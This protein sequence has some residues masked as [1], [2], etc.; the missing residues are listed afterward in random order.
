MLHLVL[1]WHFHQPD[2]RTDSG[3]ACLPWTYL[4]ALKDY[5]DMAA[6]LEAVPAVRA[7]VNFVPT[8]ADQLDDYA[9]QIQLGPVRDPLLAR[10]IEPDLDRIDP[11]AKRELLAACFRLNRPTMLDP[12][13]A[14]ARLYA[15]Y[16]SALEDAGEGVGYL[17]GQYLADLL[18]WYHLAWMGESI[19]RSSALVARL[20]GQGHGFSLADREA[21][22]ALI[23]EIIG[24]LIP[25]YRALAQRGQIELSSTPYSH[26]MAPLMLDFAAAREARPG[27]TLPEHRAYPDGAARIRAHVAAA[28]TS[29]ASHFGRAPAGFWPAEGGLSEAVLPLLAVEGIDWLASGEGVLRQSL[30]ATGNALGDKAAWGYRPF[31]FGDSRLACFFRDDELSDRIGFEYKHWWASDAVRH[32]LTGLDEVRRQTE[33]DDAVVTIILDG[34]NAWEYY[35][36]NGYYFL[37]E[38]YAALAEHPGIRLT[39]FSEYLELF[40]SRV[41]HLPRLL[42]GSWVYG[43]FTTWI[44]DPAK[45]RAWDLLCEAKRAFD[46]VIAEGTLPEARRHAAEDLLMSCESSDWFWWF[47]DYNPGESV[48]L[49]DRLFRTKLRRLYAVLG[50]TPPP[51]LDVPL[52]QGGGDAE[53]GGVMRRGVNLAS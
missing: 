46:V 32:F 39:T 8:L 6:H 20:M 9:R 18:V 48:L 42:A 53:G 28:Q 47:G 40:P 27:L 25:R 31:R 17:S 36:Y 11:E 26:P 23:G 7:V 10:L 2:Y 1:C 50:Q 52:A 24:G 51:A 15:L 29:H 33:G 30:V 3:A 45:N 4:H 38:L 12:F 14:Y 13:P 34:E 5:S 35:P 37:S 44:G 19:R 43:D 22:F 41:G 16:Q 21:L 49:F